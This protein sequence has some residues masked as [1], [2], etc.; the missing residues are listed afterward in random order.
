MTNIVQWSGLIW[1]WDALNTIMSRVKVNACQHISQLCLG[2]D[3]RYYLRD[4][5]SEPARRGHKGEICRLPLFNHARKCSIMGF[6]AD[7]AQIVTNLSAATFENCVL[8]VSPAPTR[9]G[10]TAGR[11]LSKS[12][13]RSVF[14][15]R[16]AYIIFFFYQ[17]SRIQ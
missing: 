3:L 14:I 13:S 12:L 6:D 2:L 11:P 1:I 10:S 8:I 7:L 4:L 17:N 16:L 15:G 9:I 5:T